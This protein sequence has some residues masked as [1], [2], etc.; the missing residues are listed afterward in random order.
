MEPEC[1]V[2]ISKSLK[3]EQNR[4]PWFF[5]TPFIE[6]HT[7]N[8]DARLRVDLLPKRQTN[9][10]YLEISGVVPPPS[11]LIVES[12]LKWDWGVWGLTLW[13]SSISIACPELAFHRMLWKVVLSGMI[14]K[15]RANRS[16]GQLGTPFLLNGISILI[17]MLSWNPGMLCLREGICLPSTPHH[18]RF[19]T[20]QSLIFSQMKTHLHQP[21]CQPLTHLLLLKCPILNHLPPPK[22]GNAATC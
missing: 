19:Q 14:R 15:L 4:L 21:K 2:T 12:V 17:K 22:Y 16:S 9:P 10:I 7:Q 8:L 1:D 13:S 6:S 18:Q 3:A 5:E 20:P 11:N